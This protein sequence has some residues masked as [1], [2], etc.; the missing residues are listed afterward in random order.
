[1][2]IGSWRFSGM[3]LILVTLKASD[4]TH[5]YVIPIGTL[6]KK[7]NQQKP[8]VL[9]GLLVLLELNF[10]QKPPCLTPLAPLHTITPPL[11]HIKLK[12]VLAMLELIGQVS[13]L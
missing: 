5:T 1:M 2:A 9:A 13:I 10:L 7:S 6:E 12:G 4:Y 3:Q 11:R 8:T